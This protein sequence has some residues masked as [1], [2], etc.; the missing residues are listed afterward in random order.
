MVFVG[1]QPDS[2][3]M[4]PIAIARCY[5]VREDQYTTRLTPVWEQRMSKLGMLYV[6][7]NRDVERSL[8][9]IIVR[10]IEASATQ[11]KTGITPIGKS[12]LVM[13]SVLWI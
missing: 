7:D 4:L 12:M 9:R 13:L 3:A 6:H 2:R 10:S 5:A 8:N 11:E 1:L